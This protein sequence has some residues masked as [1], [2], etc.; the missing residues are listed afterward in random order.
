MT[1]KDIDNALM[2]P[3]LAIDLLQLLAKY[4][5]VNDIALRNS[6]IRKEHHDSKLN[7]ERGQD[8]ME[9]MA[10]KYFISEKTVD[11]IIYNSHK[12]KHILKGEIE[13]GCEN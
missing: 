13:N 3:D 6:I 4:G 7:G 8:F 5:L 12:D 10:A 1:V 9:R 2:N 11:S